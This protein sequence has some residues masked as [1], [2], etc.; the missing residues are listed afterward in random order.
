MWVWSLLSC[1]TTNLVYDN[2][3]LIRSSSQR[4]LSYYEFM[5]TWELRNIGATW[6]WLHEDWETFIKLIWQLTS[7][8]LFS[9]WINPAHRFTTCT[10]MWVIYCPYEFLHMLG[11]VYQ[12]LTR[13]SAY[14]VILPYRMYMARIK[15]LT[16]VR[17]KARM[18]VFPDKWGSSSLTTVSTYWVNCCIR[19][20]EEDHKEFW[21]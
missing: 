7:L 18:R 11:A 8:Q 14:Q 12:T 13:V 5:T 6:L 16:S 19:Y 2:A 21:S 4:T 15:N 1:K 9:W 3:C 17:A 10:Y 20:Q